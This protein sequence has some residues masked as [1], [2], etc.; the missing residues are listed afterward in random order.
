MRHDTSTELPPGQVPIA[1]L[2]TVCAETPPRISHTEWDFSLLTETGELRRWDWSAIRALPSEYVIADLHSVTG[3]SVLATRWAGV[4]VRTLFEG[5]TTAAEYVLVD[6]YGGY[7]TN[8]PLEDLLEMPT[9]LALAFEG[10][11]LIPEQGG[12]ARLLVP[13]L[14]L[15]KSVKWVR[16]IT[17]SHNDVPGWYERQGYHNYGDPWRQ[18]RFAGD[19]P[20]GP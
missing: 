8:L 1:Q 18:Q 4:P 16:G 19:R 15:W 17:L 6:S 7:T 20:T 12:P 5:L 10:H 9:W 3:W 2:P 11:D 13:H 14:Y